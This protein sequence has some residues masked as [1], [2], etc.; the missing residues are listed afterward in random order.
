MKHQPD[1]DETPQKR[2][3]GTSTLSLALRVVEYLAFQSQ[4]VPLA[5]IAREF[6]AAKATIYRHLVTL[7]RQG[8]VRQD[9]AT[10][11]YGAG[12]KLMVLGEA[13]R[14]RFNILTA[15]KP[16]L[17][18]LRDKTGQA[19]T[20]C[21]LVDGDL[22]VLEL[23]EGRSIIDFTTRPGTRLDLHASAHGKV[24]LTFGPPEL[25][26]TLGEGNLKAWTAH[27][28]TDPAVLTRQ[29]EQI[30]AQGWASAPE[31]VMPG[32]NT[33]ASPVLDHRGTLAATIAVV[34]STQFI[35]SPPQPEQLSAVLAC[36]REISSDLGWRDDP[37]RQRSL[38]KGDS[39]CS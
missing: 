25:R 32:V 33:L 12:I 29:L 1:T 16:A 35:T 14:G 30:R 31:E 20:L 26:Q 5:E 22:I 2:D 36:A 28:I 19:V 8:F 10:G 21:A 37:A 4:P 24:W 17:V 11:N 23:V 6:D 27:T 15:A 3:A 38:N 18:R 7:Q 34:G 13:Q 39:P 9:S